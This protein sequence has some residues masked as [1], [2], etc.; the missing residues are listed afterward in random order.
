MLYWES[1]LSHPASLKSEVKDWYDRWKSVPAGDVPTSLL[2]TLSECNS[3]VYPRIHQLLLIGCTLPVTSCEAERSFS[4]VEICPRQVITRFISQ[5][6]R[7]LFQNSVV[8]ET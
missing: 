1:D 5:H 8:F 4:T 3:D 7:R 6:S 2:E